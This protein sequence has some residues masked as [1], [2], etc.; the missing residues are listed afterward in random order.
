LLISDKNPAPDA[1]ERFASVSVAYE[2]LLDGELRERYERLGPEAVADNTRSRTTRS[3][4][5]QT[6]WMN[7]IVF[8]CIWSAL[9]YL[10]TLGRASQQARTWTWAAMILM[11]LYEYQLLFSSTSTS[12]SSSW[13]YLRYLFP[14]MTLKEQIDLFHGL[15]PSILNGARLLSHFTFVDKEEILLHLMKA[16]LDSNRAILNTVEQMQL[17][18]EKKGGKRVG[19][20]T[21][22]GEDVSASGDGA[23]APVSGLH[24]RGVKQ[25]L[26]ASQAAVQQLEEKQKGGIPGWVIPVGL[27]VLFNY[28]L[29]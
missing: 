9:I 26:N 1:A 4:W 15:L 21:V 2:T 11:G 12:S 16:V 29:K 7:Y 22:M 10:F 3:E 19:E 8:Y 18:M 27:Y 28:I 25:K 24:Y 14:R 5:N 13:D 23:A 6:L 20:N 17:S